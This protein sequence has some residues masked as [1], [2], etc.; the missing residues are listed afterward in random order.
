MLGG[1]ALFAEIFFAVFWSGLLVAVL[2]E[3]CARHHQHLRAQAVVLALSG[4][5]AL[6]Q[7][8][9]LTELLATGL[10]GRIA[11][12][13]LGYSFAGFRRIAA[14]AFPSAH[15]GD[16]QLTNP[17]QALLALLEMGPV[18]WLAIP[19]VGLAIRRWRRSPFHAGLTAATLLAFATSFF[20]RYGVERDT[21]RIVS[22]ALYVWLLLGLPWFVWRWPRSSG[23][24]SAGLATTAAVSCLGGAVLLAVQ[25]AAIPQPQLAFFVSGADARISRDHWNNLPGDG[26][27]LDSQPHRSV[28]LFGRAVTSHSSLF[29]RLPDYDALL[30]DPDP[31]TAKNAGFGFVYT[32]EAWGRSLGDDDWE[33]YDTGCPVLLA[34]ERMSRGRYRRLYSLAEC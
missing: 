29:Q 11:P 9:V 23:L 22:A 19:I 26:Q 10:D 18:A 21:S 7:G 17:G 31:R 5:L 16:L 12:H 30:Q 32:D 28:T 27:V 1:L 13:E 33:R 6:T 34:E 25:I 2:L 4:L 8:G 15:L 24:A 14:P 20:V 3:H